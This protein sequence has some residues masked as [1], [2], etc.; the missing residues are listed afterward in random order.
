[1]KTENAD[2]VVFLE[3]APSRTAIHHSELPAAVGAGPIDREYELFRREIGR[4]LAEGHEGKFALVKGE[5][6]VGLYEDERQAF[7]EGYRLFHQTGFMV[8]QILTHYP[9]LKLPTRYYPPCPAKPTP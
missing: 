8:K 7:R 6:V 3:S 2:G 1:M 4:W 9:L 5:E